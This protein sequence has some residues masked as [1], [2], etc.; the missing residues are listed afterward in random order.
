MLTC[1]ARHKLQ[2]CIKA[3]STV[4]FVMFKIE[5][6]P[7]IYEMYVVF[8][9]TNIVLRIYIFDN[10]CPSDNKWYNLHLRHLRPLGPELD[11]DHTVELAAAFAK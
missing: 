5:S 3:K 10:F 1:E 4:A 11:G 9:Y 7:S 2:T 6:L 8:Y